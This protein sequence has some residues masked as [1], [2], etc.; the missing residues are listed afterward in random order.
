VKV[1]YINDGFIKSYSSGSG[2]SNDLCRISLLSE[3][4]IDVIAEVCIVN[5]A[6]LLRDTV[7][8]NKLLDLILS[9]TEVQGTKAS[10]EL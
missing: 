1:Y 9:Q 8:S 3:D 7:L 2:H 4:R 6:L 10:P 5:E